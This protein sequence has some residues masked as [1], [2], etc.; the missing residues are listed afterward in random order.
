[1]LAIEA[2]TAKLER[3][4]E[5]APRRRGDRG[6]AAREARQGAHLAPPLAA[7]APDSSHRCCVPFPQVVAEPASLAVSAAAGAPDASGGGDDGWRRLRVVAAAG[8]S[9]V[10]LLLEGQN[11]GVRSARAVARGRARPRERRDRALLGASAARLR[12]AAELARSTRSNGE[13]AARVA[14]RDLT[15]ASG[16]G[17]SSATRVREEAPPQRAGRRAHRRGQHARLA[18]ARRRAQSEGGGGRG[19]AAAPS[20]RVQ[21]LVPPPDARRPTA[22]RSTTRSRLLGSRTAGC[23]LRSSR[24]VRGSR[25]TRARATRD[26]CPT[27]CSRTARPSRGHRS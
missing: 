26:G 15:T 25:G 22:R 23:A 5:R 10:G 27:R 16:T 20:G 11:S 14:S 8:R 3:K 21:N 6:E 1:M 24:R 18:R 12:A 2:A 4:L 13:T 17:S 9:A 7:A 19:A